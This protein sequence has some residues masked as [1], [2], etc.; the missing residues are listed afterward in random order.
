L[1]IGDFGNRSNLP[2]NTP[3]TKT[4]KPKAKGQPLGA[5]VS[6]MKPAVR[7]LFDAKRFLMLL[8]MPVGESLYAEGILTPAQ[9]LMVRGHPAPAF[10][11]LNKKM[12]AECTKHY[13]AK[14]KT[15][16]DLVARPLHRIYLANEGTKVPVIRLKVAGLKFQNKGEFSCNGTSCEIDLIGEKEFDHEGAAVVVYGKWIDKLWR[17]SWKTI[18]DILWPQSP[19]VTK[20]QYIKGFPDWPPIDLVEI[21]NYHTNLPKFS[22][23]NFDG[24]DT[25]KVCLCI[26]LLAH[27][28]E[29]KL[30]KGITAEALK[31]H[32]ILA[33]K[34][35]KTRSGKDGGMSRDIK[36][37]DC[38]PV[39]ARAILDLH[40]QQPRASGGK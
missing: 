9:F 12:K 36:H 18:I 39:F 13:Q 27:F 2:V 6:K 15:S 20:P 29:P 23:I 30:K 16:F 33:L 40:L 22:S 34:L 38:E 35:I 19:T 5:D 24:S 37:A 26:M 17:D 10:E 4:V 14:S 21:N 8:K 7:H 25:Q 11:R 28:W 31:L 1:S 32:N 3:R